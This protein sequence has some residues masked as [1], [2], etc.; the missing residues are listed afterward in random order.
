MRRNIF[1]KILK[2]GFLAV[3]IF[4]PQIGRAGVISDAPRISTVLVNVLKFALSV[5]GILAIIMLIVSGII[6]FFARGDFRRTHFAKRST[7]YAIVG[8]IIS[9]SA[10]MIMRLFGSFFAK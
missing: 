7:T 10:L 2:I 6:Y 9:F 4:S 8:L 3:V 5:V 1:S